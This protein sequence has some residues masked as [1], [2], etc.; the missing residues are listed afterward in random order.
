MHH[1]QLTVSFPFTSFGIS[2]LMSK[3]KHGFHDLFL[4]NSTSPVFSDETKLYPNYVP[5]A[6][7]H[8]LNILRQALVSLGYDSN[9]A[10]PRVLVLKGLSGSGKTSVCRAIGQFFMER[11]QESRFSYQYVHIECKTKESVYKILIAIMKHINSEFPSRGY[12]LNDVFT[13]LQTCFKESKAH[14]LICLD[15][16]DNLSTDIQ[17]DLINLTCKLNSSP[18]PTSLILTSTGSSSLSTLQKIITKSFSKNNMHYLKLPS[19][20]RAELASIL[21]QRIKLSLHSTAISPH[22]IDL[23]NEIAS[24][25]RSAKTCIELIRASGRAAENKNEFPISCKHV[26]QAGKFL[27]G[28]LPPIFPSLSPLQL[29]ILQLISDALI[30]SGGAKVGLKEIFKQ[31]ERR[32]SILR[33]ICEPIHRI[34]LLC[35]SLRDF[36]L[37]HLTIE[38][39]DLNIWIFTY[40]LIDLQKYCERG[41]LQT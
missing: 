40:N 27:L 18:S 37:I 11:A 39:D 33:E 10:T 4:E 8:R 29:L 41:V 19:Y 20:T 38:G 5:N 35:K 28:P 12:S 16:F 7:P 3:D 1:F 13:S 26:R 34:L 9:V 22:A 21:S 15:D 31:Y 23:I 14:F 2:S 25:K 30:A 6:L 24:T 32:C 17:K 36:N